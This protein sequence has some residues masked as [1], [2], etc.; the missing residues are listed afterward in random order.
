MTGQIQN[1]ETY[2]TIECAMLFEERG[3]TID[4]VP[5]LCATVNVEVTFQPRV[6]VVDITL[7]VDD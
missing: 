4:G 5:W 1:V 7:R 2:T 6:H 3:P